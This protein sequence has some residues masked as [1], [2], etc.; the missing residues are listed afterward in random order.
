MTYILLTNCLYVIGTDKNTR[1]VVNYDALKKGVTTSGKIVINETVHPD[2]GRT[3]SGFVGGLIRDKVPMLWSRWS[4][5]PR[6]VKDEVNNA[7][8]VCNFFFFSVL[9]TNFRHCKCLKTYKTFYFRP[10][11]ILR[12]TDGPGPTIYKGSGTCWELFSWQFEI[13]CVVLL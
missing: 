6:E 3:Y 9:F 5:V 2:N 7:A 8:S 4:Q 11:L 13:F 10:Y 12:I 1:G